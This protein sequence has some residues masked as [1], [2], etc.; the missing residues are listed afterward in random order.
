MSEYE[1]ILVWPG[2]GWWPGLISDDGWPLSPSSGC[3]GKRRP[4]VEAWPLPT[5]INDYT[6]NAAVHLDPSLL[7]SQ[8]YLAGREM[9]RRTALRRTESEAARPWWPP[10]GDT[11]GWQHSASCLTSAPW[12]SWSRAGAA[13]GVQAWR[14]R[15]PRDPQWRCWGRPWRWCSPAP[16]GYRCTWRGWGCA[17]YDPRPGE[18][19]AAASP[20]DRVCL[21]P[22]WASSDGV[23]F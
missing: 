2:S 8:C 9:R 1:L 23:A 19:A 18:P 21:F 4:L 16:W 12:P 11:P 22:S 14:T 15:C 10:P 7:A 13:S 6:W 5:N 3:C 20:G 17:S